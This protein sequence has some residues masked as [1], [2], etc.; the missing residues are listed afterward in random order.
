MWETFNFALSVTGPIFLT[1]LVG[2]GL[3][4]RGLLSESFVD[5][6]SKLVF[7][8]TLPALLFFNIFGSDAR[9]TDEWPLL[10][11][12][13]IGTVLTVPLAWLTARSLEL[14][15]RSAFIQGAF[16]GN[17]GIIGLAWAANAYGPSGLAQA[18][19][20][21]AVIT[22]FYNA[23]AVALFAVYSQK[24]QFSWLKLA[25]DIARN[26]L[27]VAIVLALVAKAVGLKLPQ[28]L[29][30][31]GEYLASV[32]LPLALLCI[33]ASLD[34]S[35]LRRSSF[36]AFASSGFKLLVVPL[37]LLG[38]GWLFQLDGQAMAI[39]F[40]LAA[41]PTASASFIMAR[42]LGGN[43]QLAA[44]IVALSTLFSIV[45]ASLGL[46]LLKVSFP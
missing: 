42:A 3:A 11:A 9:V 32:T 14:G 44:N 21:M 10:A 7:L 40:L 43:S 24:A 6:A 15:D 38:V 23:A 27:I 12:G 8:V 5:G 25:K 45:T 31:T 13:L 30:Q 22:I 36:G 34:L 39:L 35:M 17:L 29:V 4:R 19:L 28:M 41:T 37:V 46:A 26:P 33:G 1:L 18:A 20:L 2:Y 16:R